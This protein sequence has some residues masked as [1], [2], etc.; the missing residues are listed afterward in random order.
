MKAQDFTISFAASG[1]STNVDSVLVQNITQGTSLTISNGDQL[2]LISVLTAINSTRTDSKES[3]KIYPNPSKEYCYVEFDTKKNGSSTILITDVSGK[4]ILKY[5][6]LT[7]EGRNK[8]KISDLKNGIYSISIISGSE[9]LSD[10]IICMKGKYKTPSITYEGY[11]SNPSSV[12]K[13]R[14]AQ[15]VQ[16]MLYKTGDQLLFRGSS[17]IYTNIVTDRPYTNKTISFDFTNCTDADGN[18]YPTVK[19]GTQTWMAE[20]LRATKYRNGDAIGTTI[21]YNKDISSETAPKYQWAYNGIQSNA[22]K[23]G[24]LYTL[25]AA[26]DSRSIAP[27]GWR[28]ASSSDWDN[29]RTYLILNGY[30]RIPGNNSNNVDLTGVAKSLASATN[31]DNSTNNW[32]IGNELNRNNNS[33]FG[34]L[35][36][37]LRISNGTF[38]NLNSF[39]SW[40]SGFYMNYGYEYWME[41][42]DFDI[43]NSKTSD[44][45]RGLS[46]RCVK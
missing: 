38:S 36:S 13:Y 21:P 41:Y 34:A 25:Y 17:G 12:G 19:I 23:L 46:I 9:K 44:P 39:A 5:D 35:P 30:G 20:N 27:T 2:N 1:A 29:L 16:Q 18:N 26:T 32:E 24:R 7:K 14:N 3:I 40:W 22:T 37:G 15:T 43:K 10:K 8:F 28:V 31:W 4:T 33:G 42:N 11:T 45:F 6:Q